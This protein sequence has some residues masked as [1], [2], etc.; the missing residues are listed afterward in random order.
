MNA[1]QIKD[2]LEA[3]LRT[4]FTDIRIFR[5]KSIGA[6]ICDMMS[7]TDMLIGYEIKSNLDNYERLSGQVKAYDLFFDKNYIVVGISHLKSVVTKVP[8]HWGII[9]I[10]AQS[11]TIERTA[12]L[13]KGV[14]RRHQ[15]SSLWKIELKN[16][17]IQND[18]PM[19]ALKGRGYIADRIVEK[20]SSSK[21]L[22]QIVAELK[23]RD[24]SLLQDGDEACSVEL[25][26]MISEQEFSS[27][28]LDKWIKL[29]ERAKRVCEKKDSVFEKEHN[30]RKPHAVPYTQIEVSLG[31]P[32]VSVDIVRDF[33]WELLGFNNC[34]GWRREHLQ[35]NPNFVHYEPVTGNWHIESKNYLGDVPLGVNEYGLKRFNALWIIDATLNLR[36]IK[37]FDGNK[38]NEADSI[39][40]LEKQAIICKKFS[41]WIW[42]D[43][44]RRWA[45]EQA[46]NDLFADVNQTKYDGSRLKLAGINENIVMR[47]YQ[48]DAIQKIISTNNTLLAFDVG[49]GKTYI[50]IASAMLMR[51]SGLSRK[52]MFVV[53][54][55][56]VGQWEKMFTELYPTAK[57]LT[58]DPKSF[59]RQ[60]R[61]K[62]LEQIKF[63][64][65]DGIIIA[66]SCFEMIPLS[67]DYIT[68]TMQEKISSLNEAISSK[69]A[70]WSWGNEPLERE[71][72]YVS[73]LFDSLK[74]ILP[75][76]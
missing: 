20:V 46:Y 38:Y 36:E 37:L 43:E 53:P 27:F 7:V 73:S 22:M 26:D 23:G 25:L 68:A 31:V 40:A 8:S 35:N 29:Y 42:L 14:S 64:D 54:N 75:K 55:N 76:T 72:K 58:V 17:L 6:S 67:A 50:M 59:A 19:Y 49:A 28:T 45:V 57:V 5:E 1:D 61:R 51:Q 30:V 24:Y 47:P 52:N 21:L 56:I 69:R 39:A 13:N 66:Y 33:I 18:M 34:K 48:K 60:S 44:D 74:K 12:K 11:V 10:D 2:I 4:K 15:L 71:K 32:W 65:Y 16:I 62:V 9:C 70:T 3:Y 41:E 63:G